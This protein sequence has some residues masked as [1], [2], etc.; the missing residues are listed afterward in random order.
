MSSAKHIR[1]RGRSARYWQQAGRGVCSTGVEWFTVEVFAIETTFTME[2]I[3]I[4]TQCHDFRGFVYERARFKRTDRPTI[5]VRVRP[6]K[7]SAAIC[8]G[9]HQSAPGYDHLGERQF[10]FIP[11]WGFLVFLLY[12][13]RRVNLG[14]CG[15]FVEG[16]PWARGQA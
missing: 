2:L 12:P 4:L 5:E 6:R 1:L 8:S 13:M 11:L 14:A 9:C 3:T 16:V 7:G 15:I 10:E